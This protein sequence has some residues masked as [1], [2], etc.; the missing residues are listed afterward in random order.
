MATQYQV[1]HS[2]AAGRRKWDRMTRQQQSEIITA[3]TLA[4]PAVKPP[5]F[6]EVLAASFA[7][8]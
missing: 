2:T 6:S 1:L 4:I 5:T 7:G 3:H 8:L